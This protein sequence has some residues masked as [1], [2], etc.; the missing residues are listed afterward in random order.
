MKKT[1]Q[2]T[3]TVGLDAI[4][5]LIASTMSEGIGTGDPKKVQLDIGE[6]DDGFGFPESGTLVLRKATLVIQGARTT[7]GGLD[8]VPETT[9]E[10]D[11]DEVLSAI[12]GHVGEQMQ[13]TVRPRDVHLYLTPRHQGDHGYEGPF[14]D[15]AVVSVKNS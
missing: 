13:T 1:T 4:R 14:L 15:R 5:T 3:V 9:V 11:Q 7:V 2:K 10:M 8:V 6:K 12:A